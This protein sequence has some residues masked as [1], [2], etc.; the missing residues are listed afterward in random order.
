MTTSTASDGAAMGAVVVAY[1]GWLR[2]ARRAIHAANQ[3]RG[4][5][6]LDVARSAM[7]SLAA[8]GLDDLP[9]PEVALGALTGDLRLTWRGAD[10]R[11]ELVFRRPDVVEYEFWSGLSARERF[12]T[13]GRAPAARPARVRELLADWEG[14]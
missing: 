12:R 14:S 4:T 3:A 2:R 8:L 10:A 5:L 1:P 6:R 9:D 11:L 13:A 7:R